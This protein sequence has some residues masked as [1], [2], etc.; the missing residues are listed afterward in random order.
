MIERKRVRNGTEYHAI[1]DE[2]GCD[3]EE[4]LPQDNFQDAVKELRGMGWQ[5][6]KVGDKE[7]W[8]HICPVCAAE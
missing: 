2:V 4:P 8:V 5:I 1:C 7:D 6:K 3:S